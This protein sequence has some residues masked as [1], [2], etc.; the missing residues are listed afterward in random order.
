MLEWQSTPAALQLAWVHAKFQLCLISLADDLYA[1][2]LEA[3]VVLVRFAAGYGACF[4]G[5]MSATAPSLGIKLPEHAED[6]SINTKVFLI[7]DIKKLDIGIRVNIK[8]AA[9]NMKKEDMERLV[10]KTKLVCPYSKAIQG[11][12]VTDIEIEMRT[13]RVLAVASV[14]RVG[15]HT[16]M[17][18]VDIA[19]HVYLLGSVESCTALIM[20]YATTT[21]KASTSTSSFPAT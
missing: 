17:Q 20:G 9:R 19:R 6:L 12:V 10:E 2:S 13:L 7:G 14:G 15:M 5:V 21:P 1:S 16:L 11:N 18:M 3:R 4:Q 8:I